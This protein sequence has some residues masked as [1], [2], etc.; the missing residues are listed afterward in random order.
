MPQTPP[1]RTQ[2]TVGNPLPPEKFSGS[3]HEWLNNY[4]III[5]DV[6]HDLTANFKMNALNQNM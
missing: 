6:C 3:A 5:T 4:G 1:W 2:I